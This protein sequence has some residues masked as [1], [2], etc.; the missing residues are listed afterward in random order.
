MSLKHFILFVGLISLSQL[1]AQDN[2]A[3]KCS[4]CDTN[5]YYIKKIG[6]ELIATYPEKVTCYFSDS[7]G[8]KSTKKCFVQKYVQGEL[9]G[10]ELGYYYSD[11]IYLVNWFGRRYKRPVRGLRKKI[12][13][14]EMSDYSLEYKG[15]YQ[16][17][18]KHGL[19]TY[20]DRGG[21]IVL[22][23]EFK[24]GKLIE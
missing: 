2:Q 19:W 7:L 17:G 16:N 12:F 8:E 10:S 1:H 9:N 14:S 23:Q 21:K 5:Y 3:G 22:V 4:F 24:K 20:Y 15:Y 6:G 11:K 18:L 13:A